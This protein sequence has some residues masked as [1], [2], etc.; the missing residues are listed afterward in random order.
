MT[1]SAYGH[2]WSSSLDTGDP[3]TAY[4]VDFYS[5]GVDWDSSVRYY[6]QS[7]RPVCQ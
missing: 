7:V 2:Y 4:G 3:Y 6:G 5:D 1:P